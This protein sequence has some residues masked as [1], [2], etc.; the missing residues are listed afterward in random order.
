MLIFPSA[1]SAASCCLCHPAAD[2]KANVCLS[3]STVTC[4]ELVSKVDNPAL[5]TYTCEG[6]PLSTK[7]CTLIS[8]GGKCTIGPVNAAVYVE[9][10]AQV[11]IT[12]GDNTFQAIVP[13][14]GIPIPGVNFTADVPFSSGIASLPFLAQYIGGFFNFVLGVTLIAAAIR[15]IWG[16]SRYLMGVTID[17]TEAGKRAVRDALWGLVLV[18]GTYTILR[19]V[20]PNLDTSLK[21]LDVQVVTPENLE[22]IP[23][24]DWKQII[25]NAGTPSGSVTNP[26]DTTQF[27]EQ[28][29]ELGS[30]PPVQTPVPTS[31]SP[32]PSP[33]SPSAPVPQSAIA[34]GYNPSECNIVYGVGGLP[35]LQS[36]IDCAT[37]IGKRFGIPS[38]YAVTAFNYETGGSALP[39][40][41]GHDEFAYG[42]WV[43]GW[44]AAKFLA[45]KDPDTDRKYLAFWSGSGKRYLE[46]GKTYSGKSFP[47]CTKSCGGRGY[48][49]CA[50]GADLQASVKNYDNCSKAAPRNDDHFDASQPQLGLDWRFSHG[51]GGGQTTVFQPGTWC[52]GGIPSVK[53][54]GICFNAP[55]LL[56]VYGSI[57]STM[58]IVKAN[59]GNANPSLPSTISRV[60]AHFAG[61]AS[62][63]SAQRA[64]MT[65]KCIKDNPENPIITI[66]KQALSIC[67]GDWGLDRATC[68]T[69]NQR[70]AEVNAATTDPNKKLP[71][72]DCTSACTSWGLYRSSG[73]RG[74]ACNP[75]LK[76]CPPLQKK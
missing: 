43:S 53:I 31:P 1:V 42:I 14:L 38:C 5:K 25:K 51:I 33:S 47:A 64:A 7:D 27:Q 60:W 39:M 54:A 56:S 74:A 52:E 22:Y 20:I 62:G 21:S 73:I 63:Q 29:Q 70:R 49:K 48:P 8:N 40:V 61:Q 58:M 55:Q 44:N 57:W 68:E 46:S 32:S 28:N 36:E 72:I 30:Q 35:T 67:R 59:V 2:Q 3:S 69:E 11:K 50:T 65:L 76:D 12:Q 15:L 41:I 66:K 45:S 9:P 23:V 26:G 17:D 6:S 10:G 71:S 13:T 75:T 34:N 24:D 19:T 4:D 16:G 37:T 18:L